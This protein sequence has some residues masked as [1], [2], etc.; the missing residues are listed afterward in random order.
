MVKEVL[1]YHPKTHD[2]ERE[3][4]AAIANEILHCYMKE[5]SKDESEDSKLTLICELFTYDPQKTLSPKKE[6]RLVK[7]SHAYGL[8]LYHYKKNK[9][10]EMIKVSE[11]RDACQHT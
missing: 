5:I 4:D 8:L 10:F 11:V 9:K 1:Q 6:E 7:I 2:S 3:S